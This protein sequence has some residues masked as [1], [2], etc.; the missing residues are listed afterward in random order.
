MLW[1]L[2][3]RRNLLDSGWWEC[4]FSSS[5]RRLTSRGSVEDPIQRYGKPFKRA[6]PLILPRNRPFRHALSRLMTKQGN[7]LGTGAMQ[8]HPYSSVN[9]A[10]PKGEL[11]DPV[12]RYGTPIFQ[13]ERPNPVPERRAKKLKV[14]WRLAERRNLLG[15]GWW[16]CVSCSSARR[17]TSRGSVEDPTERY[18]KPLM[19]ATPEFRNGPCRKARPWWMARQENLLGTGTSQGLSHIDA[20]RRVSKT[21]LEYPI[22][23]YGRP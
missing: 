8:R 21:E 11:E 4:V 10:S 12:C 18:G 20:D 22:W 23:R 7:L 17:L 16:E 14:L 19:K 13:L 3:E 9:R 2:A 15:S 5:A 6:T 1:R